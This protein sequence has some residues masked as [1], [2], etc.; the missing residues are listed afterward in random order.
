MFGAII[1]AIGAVSS[2]VGAKKSADAQAA[3]ADNEAAV[4]KKNAELV[5]KLIDDTIFRSTIEKRGLVRDGRAL[6][7]RQKATM[8]ASGIDL[9]VGTPIDILYSTQIDMFR[10]IDTADRNTKRELL[11]L[12]R[13]KSNY[14]LSARGAAAAAGS[15]RTAGTLSAIGAAANSYATLTGPNGA[16]ANII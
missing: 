1:G 5:G 12:E 16:W 3:A 4:S 13:A 9:S 6:A 15:Y 7:A 8:A 14:N 10:D 11:N 2:I